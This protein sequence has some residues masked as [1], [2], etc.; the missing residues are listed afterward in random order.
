M[1][2]NRASIT[3]DKGDK[4]VVKIMES[5]KTVTLNADDVQRMNPP[6]FDMV[7]DM[8]ELTCLNEASVLH[9]LKQRYHSDQI[10]TYSS[11]F[12]LVVNPYKR[13]PI[14]SDQVLELYRG[15]KRHELPPHVYAIADSAYHSMLYDRE[16]QSI[17]C[18][19]ESGAGKT[20]NTKRIIQYLVYIGCKNQ[21][22][23]AAQEGQNKLEQ[24]L[25]RANP[26][27][28]SFGNSKTIKNDNSS[29]F[30]KFVQINFDVTGNIS[31]S[32]IL[33]YILEKN[34]VPHQHEKERSFHIFYQLAK[35]A[36]AETKQDI[37]LQDLST[38]RFLTN[39]D[40]SV[41]SINDAQEFIDLENSFQIM[42]I[43]KDDVNSIFRVISSILLHGNLDFVQDK[44]SDQA[45][46]PHTEVAQKICHL[47]KVNLTEYTRSI[48]K[49]RVKVGREFT[50]KTQTKE[51]AEFSSEALAKALY[52][53]VFKFIV[54]RIN[55]SLEKDRRT[56]PS[57][58]GILDIA[59]FEIFESN[60][61]EQLCINYTNEKLQQLFNHTMFILEQ[62]EYQKEQIEWTFIDFGLDLQPTIDLI[63]KPI[64]ILGLLD[65]ECWF[66]KATDKSYVEKCTKEHQKNPKFLKPDFR[67]TSDMT[68]VHYAGKV[69]YIC[70]QW[71]S[72]NMDPLNDNVVELLSNSGDPF[73]SNL[74]KDKD[75]I[76]G[77]TASQGNDSPFGAAR[78]KKG[79][80]RT[81][82]QLYKEQLNNLLS[83]LRSTNANFVRCIIPNYEKKP[84]KI[85]CHLVLDQLKCN[86]VL[87]GIRI[88]RQGYPSRVVFHE[89][90]TR[91]EIL[92][93]K[94][95]PQNFMDARKACEL[96]LEKLELDKN[97]YRI[98]QSKV[99]FKSGVL[100]NLEEER[101]KILHRYMVYF[102]AHVRG[103]LARNRHN[104]RTQLKSAVFIIQRN[105]RNYFELRYWSWWRIFIRIKPLLQIT[106][107]DEEMRMKEDELKRT[108]DKMEK[109][110]LEVKEMEARINQLHDERQ[111]FL[112][113]MQQDSD[114]LQDLDEKLNS[115]ATKKNELE[116]FISDLEMQLSEE[117]QCVTATKE[118]LKRI[119]SQLKELE[120]VKIKLENDNQ[121]AQLDKVQ[122]DSKLANL[123]QDLLV[124]T[125][126]SSKLAKEKKNLEDKLGE[127]SSKLQSEEEKVKQLSKLKS[128]SDTNIQEYLDRIA[129]LEKVKSDLEKEK[130]KLEQLV[131]TLKS[132]ISELQQQVSTLQSQI[133]KKDQEI[134][135]FSVK[136]EEEVAKHND[137]DRSLRELQSMHEEVKE[138][139]EAVV[140][141]KLKAEKQGKDLAHELESL[142]SELEQSLDT[143]ALQKD[144]QSKRENEL[145][146]L[147][148][149][150][151]EEAEKHELS[152]VEL[153]ARH[154]Q[155]FQEM[156][157]QL[158]LL[159]KSKVSLEKAKSQLE[160]E[161]SG[162]IEELERIKI[163]KNDFEKKLKQTEI[164]YNDVS[165]KSK[166]SDEEK[167]QLT[168][169][170]HKLKKEYD[171]FVNNHEQLES[172]ASM[173][174]SQ[175]N[176]LNSQ[177]SELQENL[178][179][180]SEAKAALQ[181][182]VSELQ[183]SLASEQEKLE[184]EDLS[185]ADLK[186]KLA[187]AQKNQEQLKS[188]LL[189]VQDEL[190]KIEISKKQLQKE[191]DN[192]NQ[193]IVDFEQKYSKLEKSKKKLQG[194]LDDIILT[195][196]RERQN[197][198]TL[199][200]KQKKFDQILAD[201]K[202]N[203]D[204]I[205][206][207]KDTAEKNLRSNEAKIMTMTKQIEELTESFQEVEKQRKTVQTELASL[208]ETKD[209]Q[210][211]SYHDLEKQKRA[212]EAQLAEVIAEKDE[213]EDELQIS[214]D[215][216]AR[217]E[218][219]LQALK[220]NY[221]NELNAKDEALEDIRRSLTKQ[222]RELEATVED[223]RKS[224]L[225]SFSIR[226]KM[227]IEI[228]T[229]RESLDD[230]LKSKE[231]Y[232]KQIKRF[233]LQLKE[234][235]REIDDARIQKDQAMAISREND[236][237]IKQLESDIARLREDTSLIDRQKKQIENE[238]EELQSEV[239][240]LTALQ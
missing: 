104:K 64:G 141:G 163:A 217:L 210:G 114:A 78:S 137:V 109:T 173:L 125:E 167:I 56:S 29:R 84:A 19:G 50:T 180:T 168:N 153:K 33:S 181:T 93:P 160:S 143:T 223:E 4:V 236:K 193:K 195:L 92:T 221:D 113:K 178:Q 162:L 120:E 7:E 212:L 8:A 48:L 26:I 196:D 156:N 47:L 186:V 175:L 226:K 97:L 165:T 17:L 200:K 224:K 179:E 51:Q 11:I 66:P 132:S 71:L 59:G 222:V 240:R 174:E 202:L 68:I 147:K 74:W 228:K 103:H 42:D 154:N 100:A 111:S 231:D 81:V 69:S 24:Q 123:E 152:L 38:Y 171:V 55:K 169:A 23:V 238:R 90:R 229:L 87:E 13:L 80:F 14:Y 183:R 86:G 62:Q 227:E 18:T 28:E 135:L 190:E 16:N 140:A 43:H 194:E 40:L 85:D 76:V 107:Q 60:S 73:V 131:G 108:K 117:E 75:N 239:A 96:M 39:G 65:E 216:K 30:G 9:N 138:E 158:D 88:C 207:E 128:K 95:L 225:G 155:L 72:K 201:E 206:K 112:A 89:F 70:S 235:Q 44:F 234:V 139:L 35:G 172:K 94:A 161:K 187:D 150:I 232:N 53:R 203:A 79:M 220:S 149:T 121:K 119:E 197:T 77:L 82:G 106:R 5:G 157:D 31:S 20:E 189:T 57:F 230:A 144:V 130:N 211:K 22:H 136:L 118:E 27:L 122:L 142:R 219:N 209:D 1:T 10:Y 2:E 3:E 83:T 54:A 49:P 32:S 45:L 105:L 102:Q 15:K 177:I 134:A 46:L 208:L 233:S 192:S 146:T 6:K 58:I 170:Y 215:A 25:L 12:C 101:D 127:T 148:N 166:K 41:P 164:N 124:Q 213:I 34:R 52:E 199:E 67:S 188:Q 61:F 159:K 204:R 185:S 145:Q 191:L 99:F 37:L 98:G 115:M 182:K 91:Y 63:E 151:D 218:V 205:S 129:Q 237:K 116:E 110:E 176:T 184:E 21:A 133:S 198:A 214:E 36:S 126:S